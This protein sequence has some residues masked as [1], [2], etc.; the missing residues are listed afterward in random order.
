LSPITF[1][2]EKRVAISP[3]AVANLIKKGFNVSVEKDAGIEAKFTNSDY[4][5][6]GAKILSALVTVGK[7]SLYPSIFFNANIETF[8][9][10]IRYSCW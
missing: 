2:N 7:F 9:D 5:T 1:L 3:A 8:F 6:A 10:K 4:E